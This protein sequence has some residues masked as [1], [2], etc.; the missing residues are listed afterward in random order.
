M[1][2]KPPSFQWP[3]TPKAVPPAEKPQEE[4]SSGGT[5]RL[6]AHLLFNRMSRVPRVSAELRI[7]DVDHDWAVWQPALREGLPYLYRN[8]S[9]PA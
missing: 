9:A 5:G 7:L 4:Q 2:P 6:E 3:C 1:M 8:M